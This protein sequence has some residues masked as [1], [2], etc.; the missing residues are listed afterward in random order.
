[1]FINLIGHLT[2]NLFSSSKVPEISLK[3][4]KNLTIWF[5][6]NDKMKKSKW[7]SMPSLDEPW[8]KDAYRGKRYDYS[9]SREETT[10]LNGIL[11]QFAIFCGICK[12]QILL[13]SRTDETYSASCIE[14]RLMNSSVLYHFCLMLNVQFIIIFSFFG[15]L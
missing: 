15:T 6:Q 12:L 14:L 5:I 13:K 3:R 8:S 10:H 4:D 1:M 9:R 11:N 7:F 2:N